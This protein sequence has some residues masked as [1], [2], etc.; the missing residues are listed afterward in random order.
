M[1]LDLFTLTAIPTTV[2]A[3]EAVHQ[4]SELDAEA[5]SP[6]R[7][8]PFHLTVFCDAQSKKRDEVDNA[9]IILKDGKVRPYLKPTPSPPHSNQTKLRLWPKDPKTKQPK[10]H[11]ETGEMPHPFT[12]F[13]LPF[14]VEDLPHRPIPY[15]P[16]LGLVST[17]P[18]SKNSSSSSK[19]SAK[20][21]LNWVYAD[22]D[23]HQIKY[24]PRAEARGHI[25]GSW[26]WTEDQEGM[27]LDDEECLVAV[28]E[29]KGGYGWAMYWDPDDDRL[30]GLDVG[31]ERRVLRCSLERRLAKKMRSRVEGSSDEEDGDDEDEDGK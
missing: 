27:T 15:R 22:R 25:V 11:P 3:A 31:R 28:E 16:I 7:R 13:Y 17:L 12:G 24:G 8:K 30:K 10:Q 1:V 4:Q 29:E 18:P 19:I 5:E 14:P 26:D 9:V 6:E 21:K 20:P 2:G 23:T